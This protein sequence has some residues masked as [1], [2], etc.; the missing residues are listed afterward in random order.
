MSSMS[1]RRTPETEW[2]VDRLSLHF[3]CP[4]CEAESERMFEYAHAAELLVQQSARLV[5]GV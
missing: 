1:T 4:L 5:R 3:T 2:R